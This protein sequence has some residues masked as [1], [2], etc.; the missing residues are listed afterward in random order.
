MGPMEGLLGG[1]NKVLFLELE[2]GYKGIHNI[3]Y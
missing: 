2:G 1:G 3:T